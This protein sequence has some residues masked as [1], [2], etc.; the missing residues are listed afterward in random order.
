MRVIGL[1]VIA[2]A[3]VLGL[4]T[5]SAWA[6]TVIDHFATGSFGTLTV[7][8]TNGATATSGN[9]VASGAIGGYRD[10]ILTLTAK[11]SGADNSN[12]SLSISLP[13]DLHQL[14]WNNL[15]GNRSTL[16]VK[17][18]GSGGTGFA[19]QDLTVGGATQWVFDY[20][21]FA[22]GDAPEKVTITA[23]SGSDSTTWQMIVQNTPTGS[24]GV[25]IIPYSA[26][27]SHT[28]SG[29]DLA[30]VTGLDYFFDMTPSLSGG[31]NYSFDAFDT[32]TIPEPLT[33]AGLLLGIGSVVGYARKRRVA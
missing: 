26:S 5:P 10:V 24:G 8:G 15:D 27:V 12:A 25:G 2:G 11:G 4:G 33:M 13:D 6:T 14:T 22:T 7:Q 16:E 32:G 29:A 23:Y 1:A 20:G 3:I 30:A 17:Y 18:F 9:I 28:G 19:V 21:Q 31:K